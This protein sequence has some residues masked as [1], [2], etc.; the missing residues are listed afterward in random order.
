VSIFI[1]PRSVPVEIGDQARAVQTAS[2]NFPATGTFG[3]LGS[4]SLT[5]GTW[6]ISLA[7]YYIR[8]SATVTNFETA[9]TSTSGNSGTG[10]VYG[11]NRLGMVPSGNFHSLSIPQYRVTVASTTT[12]Y[13]KVT[14]DFS[15]G[16]PQYRGRISAVRV[17]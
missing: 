15:A 11:D 3:D 6:D 14:A 13:A 12:Y 10:A 4:I 8:N 16:N 7:L 1:A 17:K 5:P 2:T 9:I